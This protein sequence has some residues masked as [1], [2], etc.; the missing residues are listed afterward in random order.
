M[1]NTRWIKRLRRQLDAIERATL[2]THALLESW[3]T[4]TALERDGLMRKLFPAVHP[5]WSALTGLYEQVL[6]CAVR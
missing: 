2:E 5:L 3:A 1:N 4:M 6:S